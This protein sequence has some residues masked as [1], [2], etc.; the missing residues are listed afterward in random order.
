MIVCDVCEENRASE[1]FSI[2]KYERYYAMKNGVKMMEFKRLECSEIY[3]C[4][5]CQETIAKIIDRIK[6]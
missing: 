5:R 1:K 3:I 2:P 4:P 6:E